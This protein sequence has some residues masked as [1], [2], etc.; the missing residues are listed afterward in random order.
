MPFSYKRAV[1]GSSVLSV[2]TI[3]TLFWREYI[4]SVVGM[5]D[6]FPSGQTSCN[7]ITNPITISSQKAFLAPLKNPQPFDDTD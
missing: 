5:K 7:S 1:Q 3:P 4:S 6:P 2:S